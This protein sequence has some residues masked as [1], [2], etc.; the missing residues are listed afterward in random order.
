MHT[1]IDATAALR[2]FEATDQT[3][4]T[5]LQYA[6]TEPA[7]LVIPAKQPPARYFERIVSSIIS[8]QISVQA[9]KTIF[10][11]TKKL[12]GTI[13]PEN[14]LTADEQDLQACGLSGQKVRYLT[15]NAAVWHEIP[16]KNFVHMTDEEVI[17]ELTK[18]YGIGRWTAEM[19][20]IFSLARPDVFSSGD[21]GLTQSLYRHYP[22]LR[23]HHTRKVAGTITAWSPHRTVASLTL[24]YCKN[25]NIRGEGV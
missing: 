17:A 24:W 20:L 7:P 11:R 13:R 2:H 5:L 9:A 14:V 4:A 12:L 1:P 16:V 6:L 25:S 23:P 8:Q 21:L 22:A 10:G 3:M 15:H 18:L 19:F